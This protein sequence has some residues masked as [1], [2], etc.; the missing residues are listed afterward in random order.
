MLVVVEE[1]TGD[2]QGAIRRRRLLRI[3][4]VGLLILTGGFGAWCWV[5]V[6][7]WVTA[8]YGEDWSVDIVTVLLALAVWG[9]LVVA[10]AA[11]WKALQR[12][13]TAPR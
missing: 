11:T 2:L 10:T 5:L 7:Q 4:L 6:T 13:P 9:V 12:K 3:R 1:G 8:F